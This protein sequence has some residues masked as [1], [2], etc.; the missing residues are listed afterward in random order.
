MLRRLN[1]AGA[2]RSTLPLA[3]NQVRGGLGGDR[4]SFDRQLPH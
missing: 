3:D 1:E 2:N 4:M